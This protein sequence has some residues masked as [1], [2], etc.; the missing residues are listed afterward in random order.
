[1]KILV[2]GASGLLGRAV[3]KEFG[4]VSAYEVLGTGFRRAGPGV[5]CLDLNDHDSVRSFIRKHSPEVIVHS[6]A[7][8]RPN[9]SE[10]DHP[11][12]T[13]LN[14]EATRH[15]CEAARECGA[16]MI[17]I[18]TDYVFDGSAP[19]YFPES[20]PNPLNFYGCSKWEGERVV[21]QVL[22]DSAILR[23]PI[24]YGPVEELAESSVSEIAL[25]FKRDTPTV[26]EN[27]ATRYP[28]STEDIAV[29]CRQMIERR[30]EDTEF[31]GTFH[32]S[33]DEAFTKYEMAKLMADVLGFNHEKLQPTVG[34]DVGAPRPKDCR[35]DC[36]ALEK[37]G[38]GMRTP[39]REG[40]EKMIRPFF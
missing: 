3:V 30:R 12:T 9:V 16:W 38:M 14:V 27:W 29:V 25:A 23:V 33:G 40:M 32:W 10:N 8:R 21:R 28:T 31:A 22:P 5:Q 24:L 1:M 36:G 35:L 11:A 2:T 6:A 37:L 7:I 13:A 39:F 34:P 26:M 4:S 19:P 20:E 18:S 15:L 17:F